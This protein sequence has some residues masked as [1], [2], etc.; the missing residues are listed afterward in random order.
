AGYVTGRFLSPHVE[1]FTERVAVDGVEVGHDQVIALV[2]RAFEATGRGGVL[3]GLPDGSRPAFFEWTL[4]LALHTFSQASVDYAV[5]EAGVGGAED[6]TSAIVRPTGSHDDPPKGT[7]RAAEGNVELMILTNVDLDHTETLGSTLEAIAAEKAGAIAQ[8]VPVVTGASGVA[9]AVIT[10]TAAA[11]GA[12][13]Y[14]DDPLDPLF[15]VPSVEHSATPTAT[16]LANARLAAAGLRVLGM[17]EPAVSA[18]VSAPA[19]PGRG[20]RFLHDGRRVLLDGAHDPAAAARLVEDLTP[21]FV[22]LFGSLAKKQGRATLSVLA[23]RAKAVV[24]TEA[25][26]GE[27]LAAFEQTGHRLVTDPAAALELALDLA[28]A[29]GR[30]VIAGS[31]YLAGRL[32]PLLHSRT[33]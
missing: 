4:A 33:A 7:E 16:R 17:D 2:Q 18:A 15:A 10:R 22:L 24:I 19:L 5:M 32:R 20:E 3:D 25:Q 6:A 8:G 14:V 1:S 11:K 21:G 28:G 12:P 9:L 13:L 27:G 23:Q 26:A 30:V 29:G 31:L